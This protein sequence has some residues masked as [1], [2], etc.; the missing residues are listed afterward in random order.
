M[1]HRLQV[2]LE[3]HEHQA[4]KRAA[5]RRGTSM[6]DYVRAVLRESWGAEPS[7]PVEVKLAVV[8]EAAGHAYPTAEP[9]EMEAEIR[10]GM[11]RGLD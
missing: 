3:E 8:R 11:L 10:S 2:L 5:R 6:S 1:S 4:L 9:E 7:A